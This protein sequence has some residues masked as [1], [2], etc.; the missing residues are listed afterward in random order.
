LVAA[1]DGAGDLQLSWTRRSRQGLAWIDDVDV[2]LAEANEL[3]DVVIDGIA[4]TIERQA[5][6]PSLTLSSSELAALGTGPASIAVR[7]IGDWAGSRSVETATTL[8]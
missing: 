3:Y 2:P 7:Q 6:S 4:G 8:P 1:I 5:S